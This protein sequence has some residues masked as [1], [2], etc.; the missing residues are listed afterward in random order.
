[1]YHINMLSTLSVYSAICKLYFNLKN[2]SRK[3][4]REAAREP[5]LS[6]K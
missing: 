1:M 5:H 4:D 6:Y 3:G 2:D